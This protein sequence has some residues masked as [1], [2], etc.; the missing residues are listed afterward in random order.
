MVDAGAAHFD[1]VGISVLWSLP[2]A[3]LLLSIALVPLLTPHFWEHHFCKVAA[4]LVP[5]ALAAGFSIAAQAVLHTFLLDYVPFILLLFTLFVVAGG[6][7]VSG[8]LVGTPVT[9]TAMLA[10]GTLSASFRGTTGASMVLIR[11]MISNPHLRRGLNLGEMLAFLFFVLAR[12]FGQD[13]LCDV[14][15]FSGIGI[16]FQH[17]SKRGGNNLCVFSWGI[18][19][20]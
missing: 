1:G 8:N 2:F 18:M 7:K 4:F 20:I 17:F 10:F 16:G 15:H 12:C 5:C 6:I 13:T 3:G 11:P 14:G 9:N 19:G